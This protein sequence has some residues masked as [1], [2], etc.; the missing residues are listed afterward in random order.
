[1]ESTDC[2]LIQLSKVSTSLI[3]DYLGVFIF[4]C[5]FFSSTVK[6]NYVKHFPFHRGYLIGLVK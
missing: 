3:H 5:L 1:M 6:V 2:E 4:A